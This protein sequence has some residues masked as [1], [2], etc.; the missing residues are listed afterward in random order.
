VASASLNSAA[1]AVQDIDMVLDGIK[2]FSKPGYLQIPRDRIARE[3]PFQI[4]SVS[5]SMVPDRMKV[6]NLLTSVC[7]K[8]GQPSFWIG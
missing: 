7:I 8:R 1:T 4:S 6:E 3:L 5:S 2:T